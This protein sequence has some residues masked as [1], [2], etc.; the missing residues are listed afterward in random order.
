MISITGFEDE[1]SKKR[2]QYYRILQDTLKTLKNDITIEEVS[3]LLLQLH[4][5]GVAFFNLFERSI[6]EFGL[7]NFKLNSDTKNR[8]IE[9]SIAIV[10]TIILHWE[11]IRSIAGKY[12]ISPPEP[13]RQAYASIQRLIKKFEPKKANEIKLKFMAQ[14]LPVEGFVSN[15]NHSGWKIGSQNLMWKQIVF[16]VLCV[17]GAAIIAFNFNSL[18]GAQYLFF[19]LL[20][21]IGFTLFITALVEVKVKIHWTVTKSLTVKAIGA[22]AFFILIY[23]INPPSAPHP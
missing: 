11:T 10:D 9:D 21:S 6:D 7:S 1:I 4:N 23:Y 17:I 8:K 13:S 18:T 14:N 2:D 5:K 15:K 20:I 22:I 12:K 19:R 16:G 3:D